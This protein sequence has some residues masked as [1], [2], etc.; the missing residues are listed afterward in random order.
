MNKT[1]ETNEQK[2]LN[3]FLSDCEAFCYRELEDQYSEYLDECYEPVEL[4]GM[5]IYAS[6]MSNIDPIMFRCGCADWSSEEFREHED[7]YY[8]TSDY[9]YAEE[10]YNDY[11]DE[12]EEEEEEEEL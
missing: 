8:K 7:Q 12:I 9:D 11:L 1:I 10:L 5:T 2:D 3:H 4:A 6:E